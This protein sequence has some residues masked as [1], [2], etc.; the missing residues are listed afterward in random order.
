MFDFD[1]DT[2]EIETV[3]WGDGSV[4]Y[5]ASAPDGGRVWGQ[6]PD[7]VIQKLAESWRVFNKHRASNPELFCMECGRPWSFY[8]DPGNPHCRHCETEDS[9]D[10]HELRR[11]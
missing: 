2:A 7:S 8:D 3:V 1:P 5:F 6:T 10:L 11:P 4:E 9:R